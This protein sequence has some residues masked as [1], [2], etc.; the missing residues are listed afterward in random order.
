M[1]N[2]WKKIGIHSKDF[3]WWVRNLPNIITKEQLKQR[4]TNEN[5]NVVKDNRPININELI[6]ITR[7]SGKTVI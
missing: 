5:L 4:Y 7:E 1:F 3:R 2:Q 6:E